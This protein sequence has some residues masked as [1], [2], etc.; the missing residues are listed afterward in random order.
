MK[1]IDEVNIAVRAGKGG[2]G[3][4]SWRRE[5]FIPKG[6]P[7]GGDG[8]DGGDVIFEA[9]KNLNSL[10]DYRHVFKLTAQ[11]GENGQSKNKYGQSGKNTIVKVPI[12]TQIY[13]TETSRL[14]VDLKKHGMQK[15][16]A[17]GGSGGWGNSKFK[18]ATR[19]APNFAK[20]GLAGEER[21][22]KLSLKLIA[23]IGLVGFPNAG[24]STLLSKLSAARPKISNYPFTT[25][26]PQL[27]IV[28]IDKYNNF[29]IA[30][31]PGLIENA[32][33]G[34]GLGIH[35]LKHL[36][37][38]SALCHL[39]EPIK[40]QW[41]RYICI[42]AEL[43]KYNKLLLTL[44]EIVVLTKSDISIIDSAAVFKKRN[45]HIAEISA[46]T[47]NGINELKNKLW[48]LIR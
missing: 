38:V 39:I 11:N 9:S 31:I 1:F 41:N 4:I 23:N 40:K 36:E 30:E 7:A 43:Y 42:R 17:K 28:V 3:A 21:T 18:N 37:R 24:K 2:D 12:G 45:I 10:L 6:G 25:L 33:R 5:K 29:T 8:G 34:A 16:I 48:N 46:K 47:G 22:I 35:F 44:P 15:I 14:I 13:N 19:Q 26:T 20:P 27:G 32:S